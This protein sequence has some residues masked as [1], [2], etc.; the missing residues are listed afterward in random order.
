MG[1]APVSGAADGVPAVGTPRPAH[2]SDRHPGRSLRR[3]AEDGGRGRPRSPDARHW[4]IWWAC[5]RWAHASLGTDGTN[6]ASAGPAVRQ[7]PFAGRG[8]KPAVLRNEAASHRRLKPCS[9]D[10]GPLH[11][12]PVAEPGRFHAN[13][14]TG[15]DCHL[16]PPF[17]WRQP[18]ESAQTARVLAPVCDRPDRR[19]GNV[20][21]TVFPPASA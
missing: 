1:T 2:R 9:Q 21:A 15:E 11:D 19:R 20:A 3:D 7:P 8:T 18:L 4:P 17:H 10:A 13:S 16:H 12:R 14:V 5:D 6:G